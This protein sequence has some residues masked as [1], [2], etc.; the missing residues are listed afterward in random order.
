[1][2]VRASDERLLGIQT[3]GP[4]FTAEGGVRGRGLARSSATSESLVGS[5]RRH[6]GTVAAEL[7]APSSGA[8]L[9][10]ATA[11]SELRPSAWPRYE[12][13]LLAALG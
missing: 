13:V 2:S 6:Q 4:R 12:A 1:M 10:A 7:D 11:G 9:L 3:E 5:E 8:V